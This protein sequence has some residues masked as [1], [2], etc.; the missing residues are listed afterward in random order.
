M[1]NTIVILALKVF[2][3]S[4]AA[5]FETM[6]EVQLIHRVVTGQQNVLGQSC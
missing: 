4:A 2:R 1:E 3:K 6:A 5:Y